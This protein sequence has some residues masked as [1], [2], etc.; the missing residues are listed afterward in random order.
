MTIGTFTGSASGRGS[1]H[2]L[3]GLLFPSSHRDSFVL[4]T[5]RCT[6]SGTRGPLGGSRSSRWTPMKGPDDR[7]PTGRPT[8][9]LETPEADL[10]QLEVAMRGLAEAPQR[11]REA[12]GVRPLS[13]IALSIGRA[14][15]HAPR[16]P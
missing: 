9:S 1:E 12:Q 11:T 3:A 5:S 8:P 13:L 2:T 6:I 14:S 15:A 16:R 7:R 10:P 4:M